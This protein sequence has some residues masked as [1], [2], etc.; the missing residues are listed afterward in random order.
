MRVT[1]GMSGH[2]CEMIMI[3]S[4]SLPARAVL[5]YSRAVCGAAHEVTMVYG[6][7]RNSH[8]HLELPTKDS[9]TVTREV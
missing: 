7:R 3:Y 1:F 9:T 2:R 4:M 8:S 5:M 6:T